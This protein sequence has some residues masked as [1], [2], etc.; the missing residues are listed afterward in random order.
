MP[1]RRQ[2]PPQ[3]SDEEILRHANVPVYL[4][5]Q[6]IGW[7]TT[8]LYYALQDGR[9]PFG[10]ASCHETREDKMAWA[11]NISA[12]ALVAYKHGKLPYMGLKDL[13]KL[14]FDELEHLLGGDQIAKLI[15]RGLM[16]S[17]DKL[18]MEVT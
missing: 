10:F 4:A 2:E 5:A 7:G 16:G 18:Q 14:L 3:V 17:M 6:A 15:L 8:T 9:A 12:E 1:R 11:Y 13:T